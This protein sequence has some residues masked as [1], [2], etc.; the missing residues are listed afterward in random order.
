MNPDQNKVIKPENNKKSWYT[1]IEDIVPAPQF[2]FVILAFLFGFFL[3]FI[4][5]PFQMPDEASHMFRA[6]KL[7]SFD[8]KT[9]LKFVGNSDSLMSNP[10]Y[11]IRAVNLPANL[12]S[13]QRFFSKLKFRPENKTSKETIRATSM[14]RLESKKEKSIEITSNY[15]FLNYLPQILSIYVS[16]IFDFNVLWMFYLGRIFALMFYVYCVYYAI[17]N[18]PIGK[19]I[20]LTLA[21]MPMPLWL[22]GSYSGDSVINSLTF[23]SVALF[24][25]LTI[26][27]EISYKN[28]DLILFVLILTMFCVL[29]V[30]YYPLIL[31]IVLIP[32]KAFISRKMF[33]NIVVLTFVA[34]I[35]L[36]LGWNTILS[37]N[38]VALEYKPLTSL[39]H[40]KVSQTNNII[41]NPLLPFKIIKETLK[42]KALIYAVTLLGSFGYLDT[43]MP[44]WIYIFLA[45]LLT[46]LVISGNDKEVEISKK[47]RW[48]ILILSVIIVFLAIISMYIIEGLT[49]K[50]NLVAEGVQGRYFIPILIYIWLSFYGLVPYK[51]TRIISKK[52]LGLFL[53]I[54]FSI[55]YYQIN[56]TLYLRYFIEGDSYFRYIGG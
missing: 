46:T 50:N 53:I 47:T 36:Y 54:M 40:S 55:I 20:L 29:K 15:S 24:L 34:S 35:I 4:T 17:K 44:T 48:V 19:Y 42:T 32:V 51:P 56:Y 41:A 38:L 3:I 2:I 5:P 21:L 10:H 30:V 25:K 1:I 52:Y 39:P 43:L 31:L 6:Y 22:A 23:V 11:Y 16:R 9:E 8:L 7:S 13:F 14:I 18:T 26:Q 45:L 49:S 33:R 12:D 37:H 27:K 28:R